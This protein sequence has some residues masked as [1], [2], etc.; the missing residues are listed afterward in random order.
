[1]CAAAV[2]CLVSCAMLGAV[3]PDRDHHDH[4]GAADVLRA[5]PTASR[6]GSRTHWCRVFFQRSDSGCRSRALSISLWWRVAYFCSWSLTDRRVALCAVVVGCRR[7][8]HPRPFSVF[9][10]HWHVLI[11]WWISKP[12]ISFVSAPLFERY[13]SVGFRS[14]VT[15]VFQSHLQ[16]VWCFVFLLA[17]QVRA[18]IFVGDQPGRFNLNISYHRRALR[19]GHLPNVPLPR[20]LIRSRSAVLALTCGVF[21]LRFFTSVHSLTWGVLSMCCK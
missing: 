14:D 13:F 21:S 9:V 2:A 1:M 17:L 12:F 16:P 3:G 4:R 8:H 20:V 19:G 11:P 6:T 15:F 5:S 10:L 18:L 7:P